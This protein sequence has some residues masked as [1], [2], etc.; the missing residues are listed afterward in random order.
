MC[1]LAVYHE[2]QAQNDALEEHRAP[3]SLVLPR[4]GFVEWRTMESPEWR[5]HERAT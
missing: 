5:P 2:L 3:V 4:R 1:A